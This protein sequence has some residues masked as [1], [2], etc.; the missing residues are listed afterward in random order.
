MLYI[1]SIFSASYLF[2]LCVM[3]RISENLK[4]QKREIIPTFDQF[5][6]Q[7][8]SGGTQHESWLTTVHGPDGRVSVQR[9]QNSCSPTSVK[10]KVIT[11]L[12]SVSARLL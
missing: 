1:I 12:S 5:V 4:S 10:S 8:I 2:M 9:S 3:E 6:F 11:G 7:N